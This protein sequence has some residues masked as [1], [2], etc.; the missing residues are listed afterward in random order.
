MVLILATELVLGQVF[1]GGVT[2]YRLTIW[3]RQGAV[4]RVK[5]PPFLHL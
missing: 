3:H 2:P 4:A 5:V 1:N